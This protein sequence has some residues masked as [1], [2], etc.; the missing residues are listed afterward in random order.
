MNSQPSTKD[1]TALKKELRKVKSTLKERKAY[2]KSQE[3]AIDEAISSYNIRLTELNADINTIENKKDDS[4]RELAD[5][6]E[7]NKQL[8]DDNELLNLKVNNLQ[9][10]YDQG[11]AK[12]KIEIREL[13]AEKQREDMNLKHS[14]AE[15]TKLLKALALKE[16]ELQTK[17]QIL[18][19]RD[20]KQNLG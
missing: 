19:E 15:A 9:E 6:Q 8:H 16:R 5:L 4:L 2:L 10:V 18:D 14:Q 3:D 1:L 17:E 13:Q 11:V 20:S 12:L 7:Q